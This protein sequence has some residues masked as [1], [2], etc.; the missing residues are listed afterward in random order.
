MRLLITI[1]LLVGAVW[2]YRMA[3]EASEEDN[4]E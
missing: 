2:W 3:T 4:Y 1:A